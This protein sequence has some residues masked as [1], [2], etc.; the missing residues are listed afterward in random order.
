MTQNLF[1]VRPF[2]HGLTKTRAKPRHLGRG[3]YQLDQTSHRNL[4][5]KL[6]MRTPLLYADGIEMSAIHLTTTACFT[7]VTEPLNM[8]THVFKSDSLTRAMQEL[9]RGY[10]SD[11]REVDLV[12]S[13]LI[14]ANLT[15]H[16]SH[17]VGM[18]PRYTESFLEG[19]LIPN[20]HIQ[21]R[22]DHQT[23][24][25]LDGCSG[26][27]QVV[28]HEAM[29]EAM[30]RA[31]QYG[32]C[33]MALSNAHHL[34]R[35]GA[36]A[37]MAIQNNL[38]SIH[39]VNVLSDPAVAAWDGSDARFGTNPFCVGIPLEGH[40]PVILDFATSVIAKG[41][42]RVAHNKGESL[43]PGQL[44][45]HE[46][47]PTTDPVH[48]IRAPFGALR[49]FGEHKGWGLALVCE[50]LGGALA[51]GLTVHEYPTGRRVGNGMLT[52]VIDPNKLSPGS[53]F[54]DE[55]MAFID[56]VKQSPAAPNS[57]GVKIAGEPERQT[58]IK[59]LRDGIPVDDNSWQEILR[60]A[61]SLNVDP[62][63]IDRLA[64]E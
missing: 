3:G 63:L 62:Q 54:V 7:P 55:A 42:A 19:G 48:A 17:G 2:E 16:D 51:G 59:R 53:V 35:I 11:P 57:E 32:S 18:L 13:N 26:F 23:L 14:E 22:L 12:T 34:C 9:V 61:A 43:S 30:A 6:G 44:I 24:L 27:G 50:L 21:T 38:I 28:G 64:R 31:K 25:A 56:W 60:A 33:I 15:G 37:E 58:R 5:K 49:A 40:E 52:I 46:G 20:A 45:D 4:D 8:Q 36:W 1:Y 41:K 47:N 39:F 29:E 10:G